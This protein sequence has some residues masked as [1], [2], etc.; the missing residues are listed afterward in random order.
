MTTF[1]MFGKYTPGAMEK[2]SAKRTD[3]ANDII[4]DCGGELKAAYALLGET[5][6]I[7][8]VE[9]PNIEMALKASVEL[10][11]QLGITFTTTPA[12]SMDEFDKLIPGK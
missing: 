8:L 3:I 7:A 11:R 5:D 6:I 2:I 12:V 1:I 10:S 9:F 4:S